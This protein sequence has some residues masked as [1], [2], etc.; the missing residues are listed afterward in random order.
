[1]IRLYDVTVI[2]YEDDIFG[3]YVDNALEKTCETFDSVLACLETIGGMVNF[4]YRNYYGKPLD[5]LENL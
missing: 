1:M 5:K 4:K 2:H 3:I